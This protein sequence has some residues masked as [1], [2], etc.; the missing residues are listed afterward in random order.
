MLYSRQLHF[1]SANSEISSL[2]K[3]AETPKTGYHKSLRLGLLEV[4]RK[5]GFGSRWCDLLCGLLLSSSSQVLLNGI[6]GEFIQ[7]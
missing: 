4:L 7:H 1:G 5:F 2:P 3:A 6:P